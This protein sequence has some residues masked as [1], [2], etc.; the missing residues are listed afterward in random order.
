MTKK[1]FAFFVLVYIVAL[2][3]NFFVSIKYPDIHLTMINFI[4]TLL[5]LMM[6]AL[7]IK[8]VENKAI[9][10]KGLLIFSSF[11]FLSSVIIY[12]IMTFEHLM[13]EYALLDVLFSIQY[14][15]YIVFI[16]PL[17]GLNYIF[18]L[19]YGVFSLVISIIYFIAAFWLA[20]KKFK[21]TTSIPR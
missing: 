19:N 1:N 7:L 21:S 2:C 13:F 9:V 6:F 16:T 20:L 4:V 12:F 10:H 8:N 11:G 5:F 18:N 15:L 3:I 17:F 14:P